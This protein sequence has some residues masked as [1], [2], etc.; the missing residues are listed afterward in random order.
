M[1]IDYQVLEKEFIDF[2]D[3]HKI[4]ILATIASSRRK[5]SVSN[6]SRLFLQNRNF[7]R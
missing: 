2:I 7:P 5:S 6:L 3:T 1:E 4:L